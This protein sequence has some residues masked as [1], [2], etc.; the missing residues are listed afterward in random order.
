MRFSFIRFCV[1]L[2]FLA[3]AGN[4]NALTENQ[5]KKK[6]ATEIDPGKKAY[7][8]LQ[9]ISGNQ[10]KFN[11]RIKKYEKAIIRA[12]NTNLY[13]KAS[14]LT[15]RIQ[16]TVNIDK[17]I[18][19]LKSVIRAK[20]MFRKLN[21]TKGVELVSIFEANMY[22]LKG[23][24][25]QSASIY[26]SLYP[27]IK[28]RFQKNKKDLMSYNNY[29]LLLSNIAC[30]YY[31][32]NDTEKAID[33][34]NEIIASIDKE[35]HIDEY[36]LALYYIGSVH[37]KAG[38]EYKAI[39]FYKKA[40][41]LIQKY[42]IKSQY[43]LNEYNV[44]VS[45]INVGEFKEADYYLKSLVFEN[46]QDSSSILNVFLPKV[47]LREVKIAIEFK[48]FDKAKIKLL[49]LNKLN[50]NKL[51]IEDR[52]NIYRYN[53]RIY[54]EDKNWNLAF[55]NYKKWV[56]EFDSVRNNEYNNLLEIQRK[57]L[58]IEKQRIKSQLEATLNKKDEE[59]K[60]RIQ[61]TSIFV[62]VTIILLLIFLIS[63]LIRLNKSLQI[64]T[65][66]NE[67]INHNL[68]ISLKDKVI[69]L[70][71]V[72]HRVKNN[73]QIIS[74]LLNLQ[75]NQLHSEEQIKPLLDAKD[76][77]VSMSLV[78]QK[79]Y[80]E[81][82]NQLE[83]VL[84]GE[85]LLDLIHTISNAHS[86]NP[87]TLELTTDFDEVFVDLNKAV[88]LALFSNEVIT[89]SFK[90][91]VSE[92]GK[93]KIH[94]RLKNKGA[95]ITELFFKDSGKGFNDESDESSESIGSQLKLLLSQQLNATLE[96]Y[97]DNGACVHLKFFNEME[98]VKSI[99]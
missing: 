94:V 91:G 59:N 93:L 74:S 82:Q 17:E 38:N 71:E 85:Y 79:L 27:T 12:K 58:K 15:Y 66:I 55:Y 21:E 8:A 30:N 54:E 26:E 23:D 86:I 78:H 72:H 90:Y 10:E 80:S 62:G 5:I 47:I 22:F 34:M 31:Q 45:Y 29:C 43:N 37:S 41:E 53:S 3:F 68:S 99:K 20:K 7:Y 28:K 1:F 18:P 14:Y 81:K 89:N 96:E 48:Q 63:R 76:R 4:V 64:K 75:A 77:I 65:K 84:F 97:N 16:Y 19:E 69:L 52:I 25:S 88:P 33:Y 73:F 40:I 98:E 70:Q 44:A 83:R 13:G 49:Q 60:N 92:N 56:E 50:I 32:L 61:L 95:Y 39:Y 9:L 42:Q 87:E 36:T 57:F 24:Y 11:F 51:K 46:P 67:E 35:K 2:L 6:Y